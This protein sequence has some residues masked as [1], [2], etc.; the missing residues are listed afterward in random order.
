MLEQGF[1]LDWF[2]IPI[3]PIDRPEFG[4]LFFN[5]PVVSTI[6]LEVLG[7]LT[8]TSIVLGDLSLV[9]LSPADLTIVSSTPG[10]LTAESIV[11]GDLE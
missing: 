5:F 4:I 3:D 11:S 6:D 9:A 2:R 8:L 10:E 7:D 1:N